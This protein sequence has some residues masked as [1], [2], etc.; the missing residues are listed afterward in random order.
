MRNC[1]EVSELAYSPGRASKALSVLQDATQRG[2]NKCCRWWI[3]IEKEQAAVSQ[4]ALAK[5]GR[6]T[7]DAAKYK[8][9]GHAYGQLCS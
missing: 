1:E 8:L 5:S 4:S 3:C 7:D 2:E 6:S 9:H